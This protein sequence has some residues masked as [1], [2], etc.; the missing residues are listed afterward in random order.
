[1]LKLLFGLV[2]SEA[3]AEEIPEELPAAEW[4]DAV[5]SEEALVAYAA[6]SL[7]IEGVLGQEVDWVVRDGADNPVD[8]YWLA[9]D[10]SDQEAR[11]L[12]NKEMKQAKIIQ[13]SAVGLGATLVGLAA[14]PILRID[15]D[16][17]K[18]LWRDY[19]DRVE[20]S[21]FDSDEE[22]LQAL[23]EQQGL[24]LG[25]L[26]VYNTAAGDNADRRWTGLALAGGGVMTMAVSPYAVQGAVQRRH[27]P[28]QLWSRSRAEQ[29]V[30]QHNRELRAELGLPGGEEPDYGF[31]E[32]A[33]L[34]EPASPAVTVSPVLAPNYVGLTFRF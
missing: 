13:W 5:V 29:L 24:Y 8:S 27:E 34:Y 18:P 33:R 4:G 16:I 3:R 28:A 23:D 15:H 17:E 10:T 30:E 2:L 1:M 21:S 25:D 11:T 31:E 26:G 9:E 12:L 14:I 20:R 22:Y 6:R 19:E 7:R 32:S